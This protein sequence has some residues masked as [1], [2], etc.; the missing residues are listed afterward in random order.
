MSLA[1]HTATSCGD[2]DEHVENDVDDDVDN[3]RD[4]TVFG[5]DDGVVGRQRLVETFH[6]ME[7]Y[8]DYDM[9]YDV[10]C[11]VGDLSDFGDVDCDVEWRYG[12]ATST[13]DIWLSRW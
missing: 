5:D 6:D 2:V 7:D 8:V 10:N 11:D 9:D 13:I 1:T 12:M 3:D 4:G